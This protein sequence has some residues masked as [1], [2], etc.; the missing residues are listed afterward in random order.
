M[1]RDEVLKGGDFSRAAKPQQRIN[2]GFQALA[3]AT[4]NRLRR[5]RQPPHAIVAFQPLR[6]IRQAEAAL[7]NKISY[8]HLLAVRISPYATTQNQKSTTT[9]QSG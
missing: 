5:R 3:G 1:D 2:R 9:P 7:R 4:R 8:F 6:H